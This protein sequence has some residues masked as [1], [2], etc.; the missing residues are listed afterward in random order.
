MR[1]AM[2]KGLLRLVLCTSAMNSEVNA[3]LAQAV[4]LI[5]RQ[6][7]MLDRV[8]DR[9]RSTLEE[10]EGA[11]DARSVKI[12]QVLDAYNFV[13]AL[14]ESFARY[15]KTAFSIPCLNQKDPAYRALTAALGDIKD[16]RDQLQHV[17]NDIQNDNY[18]PL[19]GGIGWTSGKRNYLVGLNDI[20][21]KRSS[22]GIPFDTH[23]HR[24]ITDFCFTYGD[25]LF[26]LSKAMA[27]VRAFNSYLASAVRIEI[28]AKPYVADQHFSAM[29]VAFLTQSEV[30]C[31]QRDQEASLTAQTSET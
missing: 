10:L 11:M 16:A 15:Q 28:D 31:L 1:K 17:N 30:E 8:Y 19:L 7:R 5:D 27:G 9:G 3:H 20:G 29:S 25:K 6:F 26:D 4:V 23:N 18:G 12:E 24:Y 2:L 13:F 14:I 21:R 22:P